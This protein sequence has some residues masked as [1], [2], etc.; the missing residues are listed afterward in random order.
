MNTRRNVPISKTENYQLNQAFQAVVGHKI[1]TAKIDGN[2]V[3]LYFISGKTQV[4]IVFISDLESYNLSVIP[5]TRPNRV[6]KT[7]KKVAGT[8]K[9]EDEYTEVKNKRNRKKE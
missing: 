9:D 8:L 5:L 6:S 7:I 4:K 1:S 3:T 2:R